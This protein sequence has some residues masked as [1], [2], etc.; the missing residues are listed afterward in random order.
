MSVFTDE[1][2][3][4]LKAELPHN[5]STLFHYSKKAFRID[6]LLHRLEAAETLID[7]VGGPNGEDIQ[8]LPSYRAWRRSKG[9]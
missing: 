2:L 8:H 3:A 1:E 9:E 6:A 7:I 4:Y 5:E